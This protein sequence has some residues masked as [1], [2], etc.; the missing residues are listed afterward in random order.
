MRLSARARSIIKKGLVVS[1]FLMTTHASANVQQELDNMFGSMS[2][3][4]E[5]GAY[6]TAR[7]GVLSGGSIRVRN[8]IMDTPL[9]N[10]RAPSAQGGCGGIDMFAGSFSFI[11]ADQ[12]VQMLRS[13]AA[14]ATGYAFQLALSAMCNE[15]LS[16][17]A[18]LQSKIQELNQQ[19]S[20]SCQL[21]Q[22]LVNDTAA[23]FGAKRGSNASIKSTVEGVADVFSSSSPG[24]NA[25]GKS[26]SEMLA[27]AGKLEDCKDKGNVLWCALN[28][29]S[30][31]SY[32]T[33]ADTGI[34]E[35]IMSLTGSVIIGE[36]GQASDQY[37]QAAAITTLSPT[38][39]A[40]RTL[41]TG[42][43][44]G[45]VDVYKCDESTLC[46]SPTIQKVKIKG[47]AAMID[48]AYTKSGGII[49]KYIAN[50]Q[51]LTATERALVGSTM[52]TNMGGMIVQ[53]VQKNRGAAASFVHR[54][55][56]LIAAQAVN[57]MLQQ[58]IAAANSASAD[59]TFTEMKSVEKMI[60]TAY[61]RAQKDYLATLN[62]SGGGMNGMVS[63]FNSWM[64]AMPPTY[65][66]PTAPRTTNVK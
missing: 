42:T 44:E 34:Q 61:D 55:S 46:K 45:Q 13:V 58:M 27:A 63:T 43:G 4:T 37:G 33:Y 18:S 40:F 9:L 47:L 36:V 20:N 8:K 1:A 38:D 21:A 3:V 30:I 54:Y 31:N 64:Q 51:S 50:E 62:E 12:F 52:G 15:C 57:D 65:T 14:N 2:N 41:L 17:I 32:F 19:A 10:M 39:I 35:A 60:T 25:S 56:E 29:H 26:A 49:D 23:A 11:N 22:G 48:E 7:R 59:P 24:S 28:S 5:P 6:E 53:L 16:N 66:V